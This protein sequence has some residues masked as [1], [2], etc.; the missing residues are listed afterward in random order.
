MLLW[1]PGWWGWSGSGFVFHEGYW[2]PQVGF[3]G[4]INYGYGY[5]GRGFEGGQW[6]GDHFYYNRAVSNVNVV[7]VHN[8]YNTTVVNNV[9]VSR[10][11]QR[12]S[13]WGYSTPDSPGA[14]PGA[15]TAYFTCTCA[16]AARAGSTFEPD[17]ARFRQSRQ[18]ANRCCG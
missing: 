10:Q 5:F 15:A 11:L 7:N 12:R 2:A 1:T 18:A 8:T 4:G 3:Y 14:S 16:S 9:T 6:Q 17:S 13:R